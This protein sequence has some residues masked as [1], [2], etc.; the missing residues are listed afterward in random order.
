M[1]TVDRKMELQ[2]G[3]R[4]AEVEHAATVGACRA[5]GCGTT[6]LT[7][8]T[9]GMTWWGVATGHGAGMVFAFIFAALLGI[10]TLVVG[11]ITLFTCT[12][13]LAKSRVDLRHWREAYDDH[14]VAEMMSKEGS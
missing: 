1:K 14:L 12:V 11:G 4:S 13:E 6:I 5:L 3:L 2:R 9:V 7:G 8:L 10:A